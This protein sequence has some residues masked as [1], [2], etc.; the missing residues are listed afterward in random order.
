M[1]K[2]KKSK[3]SP[4]DRQPNRSSTQRLLKQ[5]VT[6][7]NQG[8][9]TKA[10]KLYKDI[11]KTEP[12]NQDALNLSGLIAFYDQDFDR[13]KKL[14]TKAIKVNPSV[15]TFHNNLSIIFAS[16]QEYE[17]ARSCI[18]TALKL[19]PESPESWLQLGNLQRTQLQNEASIQSYQKSLDL[20][21]NQPTTLNNIGNALRE[22]GRHSEA[23]DCFNKGIQLDPSIPELYNNLG[24]T[25]ISDNEPGKAIENFQ[26]AIQYKN[27]FADPY[28]NI[29]YLLFRQGRLHQAL[30]YLHKALE[31][32]PN[33]TA[34]LHNLGNVYKDMGQFDQAIA[35]Y[36]KALSITPDFTNV[37]TNILVAM[38]YAEKPDPEQMFKEAKDWNKQHAAHLNG[39]FP[40][41]KRIDPQKPLRIGY[42][43][44]DFCIHSV[45]F[46][47]LPLLANQNSTDIETFCYADVL[48]PDHMTTQLQNQADHW[49]NILGWS[50]DAVA[51]RI[52]DD[53]ID[54]LI[55]L[56]GH[57]ANNRLLVFARKP[58]PVQASW[59]GYPNTT[60]LSTIDYRISDHIAD[61]E[62]TT[63]QFY[64]EKIVRLPHSF[65]CYSPPE[66]APAT[67]VP[68]ST[69][70]NRITFGS[71][72]NITKVTKEVVACWCAIMQQIP[73]SHILLKGLVFTEQES[74]Q[75]FFKL[76]A[77]NGITTD[78]IT[79]KRRTETI[80]E[81][82]ATYNEID[83]AL[84]PFPYNGTTT[85]CEALWMGAPVIALAGD[86]HCARVSSSILENC[87]LAEL[88]ARDKDEY[89]SKAVALAQNQ[90][91]LE[92]MRLTMRDKLNNSHLC[93][94]KQ[95][96][97]EMEELFLTMRTIYNDKQNTMEITMSPQT[98][99]D[100]L[101]LNQQGEDF[102]NAGDFA[103][104][105]ECF[106]Q[107]IQKDPSLSQSHNNLGVLFFH[108]N[109]FDKAMT[110]FQQALTLDPADESALDN[111][112]AVL[113]ALK[114]LPPETETTTHETTSTYQSA[115]ELQQQIEKFPF[116]YHKI[117][118]PYG[119]TTPGYAPTSRDAYKIPEDLTGKR[120]LDVGAWDGHWTFEA[121][122]RGAKE[123]I[124]IDD[125]SDYLGALKEE[126]RKAWQTFDFCKEQL[127]YND[128]QC[129]RVDMSVYDLK[130]ETFG[131][132]DVVFF[133]GTLY[134]LRHPLL[135]LDNLA[136]VC[137]EEIYVESAI[138]DD[139]SPYRGGLKHGYNNNDM[140]MEFY[141]TKEYGG[142]DSNWFCPTLQCMVNLVIAAGFKN[143]EGWKLTPDP[144]KLAHCRGYV[145]GKKNQPN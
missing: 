109:A 55:D 78:R 81:H 92:S 97:A 100:A 68:P 84:D 134:H 65:L 62:G 110:C 57:T 17:Q 93:N 137:T 42:I 119:I 15:P 105:E 46:F 124:A 34:A 59:L 98:E 141:P 18:E 10:A 129:K 6:L 23:K 85:T 38:N 41:K 71:F 47:F 135:A 103:K 145:K 9:R 117:N 123:V 89:I 87:G 75:A 21:P 113:Q 139:F 91:R 64:T 50:D 13:A 101:Q 116:W 45:S 96:C 95:F 58:A 26:K 94:A 112:G 128:E 120:V 5:A 69:K 70:N 76:F 27:D 125:F 52:H 143:C 1:S 144:Q 28:N 48:R 32:T 106:E 43:S 77:N 107:A 131:T 63:D 7:H 83:I 33:E 61:P 130:P 90:P 8:K 24:N 122:R 104:A 36:R 14:I 99:S 136:A 121:L 114:T 72:N 142:N 51:Q 66:T 40:T 60:G 35:T 39:Y 102:F 54:I 49:Q 4:T 73:E 2:K 79:L 11:L 86:I 115:E 22:L 111:L 80:E 16:L 138:L 3:H 37:H 44:P 53:N 88:I 30:P 56:A 25:Y 133:F 132:F 118:L 20:N 67:S 127:G 19:N 29:G 12:N 74:Q 82:L 31:I 126:D 108:T 140:V